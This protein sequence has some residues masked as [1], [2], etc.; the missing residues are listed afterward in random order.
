MTYVTIPLD[1]FDDLMG[2]LIECLNN[3]ID[4]GSTDLEKAYRIELDRCNE[5]QKY[6]SKDN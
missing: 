3:A 5:I 2:N 1:L 6:L 4:D